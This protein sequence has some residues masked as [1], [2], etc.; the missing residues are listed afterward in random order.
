MNNTCGK[1]MHSRTKNRGFTVHDYAK[2]TT[3]RVNVMSHTKT[4]GYVDWKMFRTTEL[5]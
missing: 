2:I 1:T 4:K 3:E 5:G